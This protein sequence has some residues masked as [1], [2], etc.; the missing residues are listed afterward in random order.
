MKKISRLGYLTKSER[1]S[2]CKYWVFYIHK[3]HILL[4]LILLK[5][6]INIKTVKKF[7]KFI[8]SQA[9]MEFCLVVNRL[10]ASLISYISRVYVLSENKA[11]R[12]NFLEFCL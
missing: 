5:L 3:T 4:I 6:S 9:M 2:Q 11:R 7:L 10:I 8:V 1:T 12:R